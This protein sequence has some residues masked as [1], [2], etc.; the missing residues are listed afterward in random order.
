MVASY[1]LICYSVPKRAIIIYFLQPF[2]RTTHG[3]L[4]GCLPYHIPK[5]MFHQLSIFIS[6]FTNQDNPLFRDFDL[7]G[8]F[9]KIIPLNRDDL[10]EPFDLKEVS[11]G[12]EPLYPV[13]QTDD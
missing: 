11:S 3:R 1:L 8:K 5:G 2:R 9:K 12:F 10:G 4:H 7:Y 6:C 13:L